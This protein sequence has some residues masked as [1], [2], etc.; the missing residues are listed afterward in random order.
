MAGLRK[1]SI[2]YYAVHLRKRQAAALPRLSPPHSFDENDTS[3][4]LAVA[5]DRLAGAFVLLAPTQATGAP[6]SARPS[7]RLQL[8]ADAKQEK[9]ATASLSVLGSPTVEG[10]GLLA[11]TTGCSA[12]VVVHVPL[13]TKPPLPFLDAPVMLTKLDMTQMSLQRWGHVKQVFQCIGAE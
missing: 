10:V 12:S 3:G 5:R 8:F 13:P 4:S 6:Q 9:V 11:E 1:R 7:H 2:D